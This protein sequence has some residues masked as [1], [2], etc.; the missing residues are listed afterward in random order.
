MRKRLVPGH[1][2]RTPS[3]LE[4]AIRIVRFLRYK[5]RGYR[6]TE[7]A[8]ACGSDPRTVKKALTVMK[9]LGLV[10]M[11]LAGYHRKTLYWLTVPYKRM[12]RVNRIYMRE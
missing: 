12:L 8:K 7:I 5:Q 2:L 9:Q 4:L 10:K 11:R 3:K 1:K 6:V